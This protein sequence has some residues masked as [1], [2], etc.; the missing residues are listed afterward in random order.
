MFIR[1]FFFLLSAI[2]IAT[3]LLLSVKKTCV[4]SSTAGHKIHLRIIQ[5]GSP[6]L[7]HRGRKDWNQIFFIY[8]I[9]ISKN[10]SSK[11]PKN[12]FLHFSCLQLAGECNILLDI[13]WY[14]TSVH[15]ALF[16]EWL[17]LTRWSNYSTVK[18]SKQ[19]PVFCISSETLHMKTYGF[20]KNVIYITYC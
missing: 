12:I 6:Q 14:T 11:N 17:L 18:T 8:K 20:I 16:L 2:W 4:H 15:S 10:S 3:T 13:S 7:L 5:F 9:V 1:A 19:E